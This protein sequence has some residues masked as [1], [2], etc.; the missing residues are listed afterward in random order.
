MP[1]NGVN[2]DEY[3]CERG[4]GVDDRVCTHHASRCRR[5]PDGNR[6]PHG[7][8]GS[9]PHHK[10]VMTFTPSL[11][12]VA[13]RRQ[14]LGHSRI[15]ADSTLE[16][17]SRPIVGDYLRLSS[18]SLRNEP[19]TLLATLPDSLCSSS[20]SRLDMRLLRLL[21]C[22]IFWRS[23]ARS[24]SSSLSCLRLRRSCLR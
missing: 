19:R 16:H 7:P 1:R 17:V 12:R 22:C 15:L 13:E 6:D 8:G 11:N 24:S 9:I 5:R 18:P 10:F 21:S 3:Y 14:A 23:P 2:S 20:S 4:G